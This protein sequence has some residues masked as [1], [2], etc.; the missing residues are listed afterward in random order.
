M[1]DEQGPTGPDVPPPADA[2]PAPERYAVSTP[3]PSTGA[4]WLARLLVP[5]Y[6]AKGWLKLLGAVAIIIGGIQALTI[7]GIVVAWLYIWVGILLWQAGERAEEATRMR[8]P[9]ILEQYL[10]KIK[11]I[12]LIVGVLTLVSIVVGIF[13]IILV[14]AI[15]GVATL[16]DLIPV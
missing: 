12:I 4:D 1:N 15:G 7:I 9:F 14:F 2:P 13:S 11:T 16:M 6:E 10:Q 3:P 8:N 5:A